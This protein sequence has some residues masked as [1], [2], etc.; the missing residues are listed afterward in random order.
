MEDENAK[1]VGTCL[2]NCKTGK[3]SLSGIARWISI[4]R[5]K[6][7]QTI[8]AKH[9]FRHSPLLAPLGLAW[10]LIT[11]RMQPQCS[12]ARLWQA[13]L[14]KPGDLLSSRSEAEEEDV[15][16]SH[17]LTGCRYGF[18]RLRPWAL[19]E[20]AAAVDQKSVPQ[21]VWASASHHP[22]PRHTPRALRTLQLASRTAKSGFADST[23]P[24]PCSFFSCMMDN[25]PFLDDAGRLGCNLTHLK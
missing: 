4:E 6:T 20:L 18:G 21:I 13:Y 10:E 3:Q 2:A 25:A 9:A 17:K 24:T 16:H 7:D 8:P 12:L 1:H 15:T 14:P 19:A 22:R 11:K 5:S 23:N